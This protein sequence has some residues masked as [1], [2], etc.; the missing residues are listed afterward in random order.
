MSVTEL[1]TVP[2]MMKSG[3]ARST[4]RF[5]AARCCGAS[6]RYRLLT[7]AKSGSAA[8]YSS[9]LSTV[10]F[11]MRHQRFLSRSRNPS[12]ALGASRLSPPAAVPRLSEDGA[13]RLSASKA[14]GYPER[15]RTSGAYVSSSWPSGL[16]TVV[17]SRTTRTQCPTS[18]YSPSSAS[19]SSI[20]SRYVRRIL[21][22]RVPSAGARGSS[23]RSPP[24][25]PGPPAHRGAAPPSPPRC[26]VRPP[27]P[28]LARGR[29][30]GRS[31]PPV[32]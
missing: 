18:R 15:G 23:V 24:R 9:P 27:T 3:D 12:T 20:R 6:S 7:V 14:S 32:S 29:C 25:G 13:R 8:S 5:C 31:R 10:K 30:V 1:K 28:L 26:P 22:A 2:G 11:V 17:A 4:K 19:A 21:T 16:R